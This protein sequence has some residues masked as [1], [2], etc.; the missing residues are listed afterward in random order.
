MKSFLS[1]PLLATGL[2]L[3][4]C[5]PSTKSGDAAWREFISGTYDGLNE[6]AALGAPE[7]PVL[8]SPAYE[9]KW[10]KPKVRVSDSGIYELNYA[11]PA[12]PFDRLAIYGSKKPFPKLTI[13]PTYSTDEE[14]NGELASVR[15]TQSFRSIMINGKPVRWFQESGPG[16]ADGAYYST[17]GFSATNTAG[18]TGY[19][20]LVVEGG[21]NM[22]PE[23]AR[24][25]S[26]VQLAQ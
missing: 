12:Q 1:G 18:Q 7:I 3:A 17:E 10:G 21:I 25:F 2:F 11:N 20:R 26:S 19:Y 9:Q 24:R 22:D 6:V 15:H 16:G 4:S 13:P 5:S 23:I 14:V 8:T